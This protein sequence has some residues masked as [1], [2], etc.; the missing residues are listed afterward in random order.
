MILLNFK[1]ALLILNT[2]GVNEDQSGF[3]CIFT[4]Y[5]SISVLEVGIWFKNMFVQVS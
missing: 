3:E 2:N 4:D 5:E 1:Q